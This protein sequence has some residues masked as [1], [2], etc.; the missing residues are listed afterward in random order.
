MPGIPETIFAGDSLS[1]TESAGEYP[2]PTWTM[3]YAI[4]GA[5]KL[6][7]VSTPAGTDHKFSVPYWS[8]YLQP[9]IYAWQSYVT[10]VTGARHTIASGSIHIRTNLVAQ[11]VGFDGRSHAQKVLDAI[12]ATMEGRASKAQGS[13]QINNRQIQYLKPEE[14][15]KWRSFYKAEVAREKTAE[16]VAQGEEPGNRILTRF[17]DD[18]SRGAW[19]LNRVWRWPW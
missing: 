14:L 19:P 16:K 9:G 4:R 8:T 3:R 15:V 11:D 18:T 10:D 7:L 1:W 12:E 2:A 17:R 6:N 13:V 5:S